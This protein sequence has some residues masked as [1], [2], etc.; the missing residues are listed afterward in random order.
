MQTAC[1]VYN[2]F[3]K[4]GPYPMILPTSAVVY[5]FSYFVTIYVTAKLLVDLS[6]YLFPGCHS[7]VFCLVFLPIA[8]DPSLEQDEIQMARYPLHFGVDGN[9]IALVVLGLSFGIQRQEC[10]YSTL[11]GKYNV[12]ACKYLCSNNGYLPS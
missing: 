2:I 4:M 1:H 7:T 12:L 8:V 6:L 11:V 9:S 5:F 10:T 3:S